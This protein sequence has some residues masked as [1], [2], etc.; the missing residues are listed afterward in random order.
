MVIYI[1]IKGLLRVNLSQIEGKLFTIL[2]KL[3]TFDMS[4]S[5]KVD[6]WTNLNLLVLF[7]V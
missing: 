3:D 4:C 2:G 6:F 5:F 7:F 1:D